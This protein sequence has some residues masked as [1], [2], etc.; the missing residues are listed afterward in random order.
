MRGSPDALLQQAFALH[1]A[2]RVSEA[3]RL[4]G[5]VLRAAPK[6]FDALHLAGVA[7]YQQGDA[8]DA[9]GSSRRP[10]RRMVPSP[11]PIRTSAMRC[12]P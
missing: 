6:S 4:Y 10:S 8:A 12:V 9:R 7:A 3:R 5:E 11:M 2:G 1:R